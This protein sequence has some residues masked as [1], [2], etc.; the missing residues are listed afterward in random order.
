MD[1]LE[2]LIQLNSKIP[3]PVY[4]SHI[5]AVEGDADTN[6][7][8]EVNIVHTIPQLNSK[9]ADADHVKQYD[10]SLQSP[11]PQSKATTTKTNYK[12]S[13]GNK[14]VSG[15]TNIQVP[16]SE[17]NT[18]PGS[19]NGQ[20]TDA[21]NKE[22]H[23]SDS[24]A[25]A[26]QKVPVSK[27]H[28][29]LETQNEQAINSRNKHIQGFKNRQVIGIRKKPKL[30]SH[31]KHVIG[32]GNK[33]AP[34]VK[35]QQASHF[36]NKQTQVSLN[37][38]TPR[39][40]NMLELLP[41]DATLDQ[42]IEALGRMLTVHF[43]NNGFQ[44]TGHHPGL[45]KMSKQNR[46]Q[47]TSG[48]PDSTNE[49]RLRYISNKSGHKPEVHKKKGLITERKKT[50]ENIRLSGKH[51]VD[52]NKQS[53]AERQH[54]VPKTAERVHKHDY[55]GSNNR[56]G[57]SHNPKH[58]KNGEFDGVSINKELSRQ[59][60]HSGIMEGKEHNAK[61][62][63]TINT[64]VKAENNRGKTRHRYKLVKMSGHKPKHGRKIATNHETVMGK[65]VNKIKNKGIFKHVTRVHEGTSEIATAANRI[66]NTRPTSKPTTTTQTVV[67]ED[68]GENQSIDNT[69]ARTNQAAAEINKDKT[70]KLEDNVS[71]PIQDG[72]SAA[73]D[74][75][76]NEEAGVSGRPTPTPDNEDATE[77]I[78]TADEYER[79]YRMRQMEG[80]TTVRSVSPSEGP[81][82]SPSEGPSVSPSEGRSV[83]PSEG[84]SVS[85]SEGRSVSPSEG[86]RVSPSEGRSASPSDGQQDVEYEVEGENGSGD[87]E[88]TEYLNI[89]SLE[90]DEDV[91]DDEKGSIED[92]NKIIALIQNQ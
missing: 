72:H 56:N 86:R 17:N 91:N 51:K 22:T 20:V 29:T 69:P 66:Q 16:T 40:E 46:G 7:H 27:N 39:P 30:D 64:G 33:Q 62:S 5:Q 78:P 82:V 55:K 77:E 15:F 92:V 88:P 25:V 61:G 85:P 45:E 74:R 19:K 53:H 4:A 42:K 68:S 65:T 35:N 54:V 70:D 26:R 50:A 47:I 10:S 2:R 44:A 24:W 18:K 84:R 9:E 48:K 8:I 71:E 87:K 59:E 11:T 21:R 38:Q 41:S 63:P 80:K 13:V 14:Q 6:G 67:D 34:G 3:L 43:P 36:G 37:R 90:Y 52:W 75:G 73:R 23:D 76:K 60:L 31:N 89:Y 49:I 12:P 32:F 79:Q 83:S 58:N 57:H 81:S 1:K 28:Q